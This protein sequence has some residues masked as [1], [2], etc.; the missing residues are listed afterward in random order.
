MSQR[1]LY[2][3]AYDISSP[4]RLRAALYTLKAYACGRQ[5]SVFE[6]FLDR[7][8]RQQLV[9]EIRAILDLKTDR[10]L[11]LPLADAKGVATLGVAV[12]PADPDFFYV[13]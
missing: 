7:T 3:A 4:E 8:E 9:A 11:L 10:F 1:N 12:A 6:C 13:G 5:K 2:L